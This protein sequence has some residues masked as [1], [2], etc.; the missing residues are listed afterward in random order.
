MR[1]NKLAESDPLNYIHII[2]ID[3]E[4]QESLNKNHTF[5]KNLAELVVFAWLGQ[6]TAKQK[7][8]TMYLLCTDKL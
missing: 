5:K 7:S 6:Q 8:K 2:H 1:T 4:K 3:D